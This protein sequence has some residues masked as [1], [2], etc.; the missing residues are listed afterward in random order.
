[1]IDLRFLVFGVGGNWLDLFF[2]KCFSISFAPAGAFNFFL[3]FFP[4]AYATR[5][6]TSAPLG[7]EEQWA[8]WEGRLCDGG[9]AGTD[10][11]EIEEGRRDKKK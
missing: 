6:Q 1:M 8:N 10:G 7:L 11:G 9:W 2:V 4:G 3:S 5:L